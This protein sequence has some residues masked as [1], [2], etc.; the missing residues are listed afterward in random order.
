MSRERAV[1]GRGDT[2]AFIGTVSLFAGSHPS[3]KDWAVADGRSL[4]LA[5]N[6]HLFSVVGSFYGGDGRTTFALPDLQAS[7]PTPN[8]YA[9]PYF[10]VLEGQY[11]ERPDGRLSWVGRGWVGEVVLFAGPYAPAGWMHADG[12]V[13]QI[14]DFEHLYAIIGSRYGGDGQA[15]FALPDLCHA[16]PKS[17]TGSTGATPG[18]PGG[19]VPRYIIATEGLPSPLPNETYFLSQISLCAGDVNID[20]QRSVYP[21]DGRLLSVITNMALFSLLGANFGGN[22]QSTFALPD[23]RPVAPVSANGTL[24]KYV[25]HAEGIFPSWD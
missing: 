12:S 3:P 19:W 21:A 22:G 16:E 23:L 25:V 13:L 11:P 24:L 10:V 5:S 1:V 4:G 8:G 6:P 7:A 9:I 20:D 14:R 17:A 2:G 18:A 15:T